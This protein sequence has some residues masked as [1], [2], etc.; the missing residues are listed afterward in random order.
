MIFKEIE[1]LKKDFTDKYVVVDEQR[2]ELKRFNGMTGVVKTVNMNGRALV[3]F[4]DHENI[5][6][7]D[8]ELD[9]LKVVDKPIEPEKKPAAAKP[10]P[11]KPAAKKAAKPA[12]AKPAAT[13]GGMS[14]TDILAA[15]RGGGDAPAKDK[16]KPAAMDTSDI[17]AAARGDAAAEK[18]EPKAAEKPA[19]DASQMSVAD[20]LAAARGDAAAPAKPADEATES[21]AEPEE[22]PEAS[23][24]PAAEPE[25]APAEDK[26]APVGDLPT[27]VDGIVAFC[28]QADG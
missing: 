22:A 4:G 18:A 2:P 11:A 15:A 20:I 23:S 9:F 3:E 6:W 26:S 5:G 1:K 28:R 16:P 13:G 19:A 14:V 12:A 25:E 17:L 24:E 27:D 8:I 21:E 10:A 7:F